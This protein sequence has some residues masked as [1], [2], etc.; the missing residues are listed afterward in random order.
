M[1][2]NLSCNIFFVPL[3]NKYGIFVGVVKTE[4]HDKKEPSY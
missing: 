4:Q 3:Q 1:L 2:Q